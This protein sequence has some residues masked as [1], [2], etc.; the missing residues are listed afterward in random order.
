M[1]GQGENGE[2]EKRRGAMNPYIKCAVETNTPHRAKNYSYVI[3]GAVTAWRVK[4]RDVQADK[5]GNT[6]LLTAG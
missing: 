3:T 5:T 4:V 6:S 2:R 1:A